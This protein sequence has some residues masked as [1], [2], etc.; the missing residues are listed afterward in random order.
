[1]AGRPSTHHIVEVYVTFPTVR[2]AQRTAETVVRERLAACVNVWP[3]RSTYRWQGRVVRSGEAAALLKTTAG[4]YRRLAARLRALH[5]YTVPCIVSWSVGRG[6][7]PYLQWV[8]AN[9]G[10]GR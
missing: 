4:G 8:A 6:H 2:Q 7:L 3:I 1:M 5:S 10:R 9:V